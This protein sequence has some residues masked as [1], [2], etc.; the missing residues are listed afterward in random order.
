M[1]TG[2]R[3]FV[4]GAD[5]MKG[6]ALVRRLTASGATRVVGLGDDAP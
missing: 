4:A 2:P 6:R 1:T 3:I 5:T